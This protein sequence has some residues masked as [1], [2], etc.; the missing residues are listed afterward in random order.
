MLL[1]TIGG[2][3]VLRVDPP[4]EEGVPPQLHD[5]LVAARAALHAQATQIQA[6]TDRLRQL[7][8]ESEQRH[9]DVQRQLEEVDRQERQREEAAA[10]FR[11]AA[12]VFRDSS[13]RSWA[14]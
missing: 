8:A 4:E 3:G 6:E 11:M 13:F 9:A 10:A 2:G 5:D 7:L 1:M 14:S 12:S